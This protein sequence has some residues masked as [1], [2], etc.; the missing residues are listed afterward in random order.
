MRGTFAAMYCVLFLSACA[1][2]APLVTSAFL[3]FSRNLVETSSQ[4][5]GVRYGSEVEQLLLALAYKAID[6]TEGGIHSY[7]DA[8]G[9][10]QQYPAGYGSYAGAGNHSDS[11]YDPYAD[12]GYTE[13]SYADDSYSE[14]S[15]YDPNYAT[16]SYPD[17]IYTRSAA[18]ATRVQ[19]DVALLAQRKQ[20]DGRVKLQPIADGD[21]LIDGRGDPVAGD[22]IKV[23]FKANCKCFVYVIGIDATGYVAQIFPDPDIPQLKNP[24]RPGKQ[25]MLP[26]GHDWWGLDE[27]RGVE[28]I[29]FVASPRPRADIQKA[30][31]KLAGQPRTIALA[32]YQPVMQAAV[33]PQPRGLVKVTDA[34]APLN[35]QSSAGVQQAVTPTS[36]LALA[37]GADLVITRWFNHR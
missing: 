9:Y 6:K 4:N 32:D 3:N 18:K 24:V 15:Y 7:Y 11:S 22:K 17:E 19:L 37:D 5:A 8:Q 23:A 20:P 10:A 1:E 12:S 31:A 21:T 29:Y 13:D 34:P 14:D 30:I 33:V 16:E 2:V 35:I 25:Y 27:F 36:F 26:K 28:T